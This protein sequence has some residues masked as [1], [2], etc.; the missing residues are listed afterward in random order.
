MFIRLNPRRL[1]IA[2]CR[3]SSCRSASAGGKK[4]ITIN[5]NENSLSLLSLKYGILENI[6]SVFQGIWGP[7]EHGHV[8]LGNKGTVEFLKE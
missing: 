5:I 2:A 6:W 4:R 7:R 1:R 3:T 8:L